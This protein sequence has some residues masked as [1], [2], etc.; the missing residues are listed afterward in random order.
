MIIAIDGPAASGK[1]TVARLLAKKLNFFYLDSGALYRAITWF[2]LNKGLDIQN[3]EEVSKALKSLKLNFK[4]NL[5]F[6]VYIDQ[7]DITSEIRKPYVSQAVSLVSSYP[8]VRKMVNRIQRKSIKGNAVVEGRDITSVVF[9]TADLKI[10]LEASLEVRARRRWLEWK[11][12][13]IE[14]SLKEALKDIQK[15]DLLDSSRKYA[16][17][18][19]TRE[20]IVIDTTN[21]SLEEVIN[22][23][24][25]LV[26][27]KKS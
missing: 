16:P 3:E 23:I 6:K 5:K 18:R 1:S 14:G 10:Y 21:L 25:N 15:R 17:L 4:Y 26:K 20:A 8:E 22:E 19:K 27:N 7:Q 9:P 12:K 13:G 2:L 11:E 24:L